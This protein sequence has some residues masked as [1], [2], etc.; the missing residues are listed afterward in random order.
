M[1]IGVNTNTAKGCGIDSTITTPSA[2][3]PAASSGRM[4]TTTAARGR[5]APVLRQ[6]SCFSRARE[7]GWPDRTRFPLCGSS[8]RD[9]RKTGTFPSTRTS[10]RTPDLCSSTDPLRQLPNPPTDLNYAHFCQD[11]SECLYHV[12]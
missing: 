2:R 5:K 11:L 1:T 9:L 10:R 3:C 4:T 6:R 8:D 12:I 7:P